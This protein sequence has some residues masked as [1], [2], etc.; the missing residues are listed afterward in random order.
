M[1]PFTRE[2]FLAVFVAYNEAVWPAQV[3]AYLLGLLMVALIIRPSAQRSRIVAAGLAAM[4]L[5]TGV[6]YHG[7]SFSTISNGAWG[8]AALFVIQGL[9][10]IE[11]GVLRGR[12]VFGLC[13]GWLGWRGWALVAYASI[14]YPLLG[15]LLGHGY[16]AMPMFGI[17]PCPV[18]LFTFGLL[19]LT[20]EPI[21][22]R[23][24]VIP[25]VWSLIGGSAAFK[26][27]ITQDWPLLVSGVTVLALLRRDRDRLR[28]ES[29]MHTGR[30]TP[31]A[32]R[33][34]TP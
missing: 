29:E 31:T 34:E 21:P 6:A 23:L 16:P 8:F 12:L 32:V 28:D 25:V 24:L 33:P 10:F 30:N 13:K 3:M 17:T 4:W 11:A 9:L 2:Q 15:Q 14:G 5:W 19:L 27:A 1:L 7:M 18:T 20:T 26:L 22:R